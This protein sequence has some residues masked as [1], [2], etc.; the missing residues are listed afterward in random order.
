MSWKFN[1][2]VLLAFGPTEPSRG[3]GVGMG[4]GGR[5]QVLVMNTAC[6]QECLD[7]AC[8]ENGSQFT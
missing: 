8:M 6:D 1:S 2:P 3:T 5:L 4:M 7:A